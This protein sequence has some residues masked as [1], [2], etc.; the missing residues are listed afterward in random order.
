MTVIPALVDLHTHLG[1]WNY[2]TKTISKENFTRANLVDQLE[3]AAYY[4][5]GAVMSVGDIGDAR[6][7]AS[8][9]DHPGRG[10][11]CGRRDAGWR[12][13]DQG[14]V[15]D[16]AVRNRHSVSGDHRGRGPPRRA[17]AGGQEARLHQDLGG[18]PQRTRTKLSP[19]LYGAIID[20]A[21]RTQSSGRRAHLQGV[22]REGADARRRGRLF[23][24]RQGRGGGRRVHRA[25]QGA[26]ARVSRAGRRRGGGRRP[27][28]A[29]HHGAEGG[30]SADRASAAIP[31]PA[32]S[33]WSACAATWS[34]A[35]MVAAGLT[36]AEALGRGH[37]Q[38][39][40]AARSSISWAP[41]LAARA[42]TSSSS[43]RTRS[44]PSRTR[45]GS[46]RSTCAAAKSTRAALRAKWERE[47]SVTTSS[48]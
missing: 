44:T 3:R 40:G 24:R 25:G 9:G 21:H 34:S 43:R 38:G 27:D 19:A 2:A 48:N 20:E 31:S 15:G 26:S 11:R 12:I 17:G 4:G 18:R 6:V 5:F 14:P 39:C 28:E 33:R 45:S 23:P 10:A 37:Q 46:G 32:R 30:R 16:A 7:H 41:W 47:G 22:G 35:N 42:R 36:P 8:P 1:Y 29:Q 13:Q